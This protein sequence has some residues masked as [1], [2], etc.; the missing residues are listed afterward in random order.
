M[1][2]VYSPL[3][4]TPDA[5]GSPSIATIGSLEGARV[6]LLDNSK[7]NADALLAALGSLL[8]ERFDHLEVTAWRKTGTGASGPASAQVVDEMVRGADV[9]VVAIGD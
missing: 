2:K 3:G 9:A 1:T 4:R 8:G 5:L 7:L 6:G